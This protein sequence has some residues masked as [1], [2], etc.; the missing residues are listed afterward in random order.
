M[1][2]KRPREEYLEEDSK[3]QHIDPTKELIANIC[4]D[5]RRIGENGNLANQI[6]D[7]AYISNPIEVEFEKIDKL[8]ELILNTFNALVIE[9]PQKITSLSVLV[10]ICN[11]KN[12]LVSKYVIEFFHSKI[13]S[14]LQDMN[15]EISNLN[16]CKSILKFLSCLSPIIDNYSIINVY[17]QFLN[18]AIDLQANTDKRNGVAEQIYYNTL[19][20]LPYLLSNDTSETM[21]NHCNDLVELAKTFQIRDTGNDSLNLVFND[22]LGNFSTP[23][24]PKKITNLILPSL[25][26]LQSPE[27]DWHNLIHKLFINFEPLI[28]PIIEDNL[29]KNKISNDIVKHPLPQFSLPSIEKLNEYK[30]TQNI[31]NLWLDHPRILFELYNNTKQHEFQTVPSI[32]SYMGLF[33]KDLSFDILTN[34]S[35]NKNETS[36]QLSIL[37]LYFNKDLFSPPGTT[38]DQLQMIHNDNKTGENTPPLSTWKIEDI[39]VESI[40]TMIFQLPSL[41]N[42][43]IYY[44]T[45]LIACCK[46]NP[47]SIAPVFGRAIRFF[48]RNLETL[49]FECKIRFM[50]WMTIQISNFEFSWKWDE[51]VNDSKLLRNLQYHPK[52]NFIKNLILKEIKLSNKKRIKDSFIAMNPEDPTNL[53]QLDEFEKYLNISVFKN[54]S[55]FIINYDSDLYGGNPSVKETIAKV[56]YERKENFHD[57]VTV[58]PQQ[59]MFYIFLNDELP[60]YSICE[61]THKFLLSNNRSNQDYHMLV[62]EIRDTIKSDESINQDKFIINLFLQAYCFIGSRSIYSTVSILNRDLLKLKYLSGQKIIEE[63]YK[64]HADDFRFPEPSSDAHE[65]NQKFIVDSIFRIWIHQPQFIFLTL[66]YLIEAKIIGPVYLIEK[67]FN[68][69]SNLMVD[70]IACFESIQRILTNLDKSQFKDSILTIFTVIVNNINE[71]LKTLQVPADDLIEI[72]KDFTEEEAD[73]LELMSKIDNQWLLYEYVGLFKSCLRKFEQNRELVNDISLLVNIDNNKLKQELVSCIEQI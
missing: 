4:K 31:D 58:S 13:Q 34:L 73:D 72:K 66:E 33:F 56:Q 20:S 14:Y 48:Y 8:R 44:Y 27:K 28:S 26:E 42:Y 30:P 65:S 37:D 1:E 53:I 11:S 67:C 45:V 57:S 38:I 5:I 3:R 7:I 71:I 69:S 52:K 17:K 62:E 32:E 70:N 22:K 36:I 35:F 43:E 16:D 21:R 61:R 46:E 51:W 59:E 2:G 41:L 15:P 60:F 10:L 64:N 55:K 47:E 12:F 24:E 68:L 63:E 49:D 50:D 23:Y 19:I 40:L 25:I 18:L 29:Q 6:D 54:E 9:Q 39:A